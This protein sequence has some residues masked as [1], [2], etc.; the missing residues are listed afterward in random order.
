M[1]LK[2]T[3]KYIVAIT[4]TKKIGKDISII[5]YLSPVFFEISSDAAIGKA[6]QYFVSKNPDYSIHSHVCSEI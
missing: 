1:A 6:F 5:T 2:Q 4:G 3:K